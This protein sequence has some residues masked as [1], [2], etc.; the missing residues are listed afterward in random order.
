[1]IDAFEQELAARTAGGALF[2]VAWCLTAYLNTIG[3]GLGE[4][5]RQR[6]W[7]FGPAFSSLDFI[8]AWRMLLRYPALSLVSVFGM[9]VGIAVAATAFVVIDMLMDTR[10]PLPGDD[11]V[12]SLVSYDSATS[13]REFRLANDYAAWRQMASMQEVGIDRT[14]A[15][16][17]IV[18]GRTPEPIR[19]VEISSSAFRVAG[20]GAI[21]GRSLMPEDEA[22]DAPDVVVIGYDEWVRRFEGDPDIIG[23]SVQLGVARH[24]IVGVM[25][26]G[27]AFPA[28]HTFWIPWRVGAASYPPRTGP[29]VSVSGRLAAGVTLESAQAELAEIGRR[30][31]ADSPSTHEHLRPRVLPYVYAFTDMGEPENFFAM[32]AMETGLVLLL[33]IVCVNVAIL[34]Y[35]RTATRQGEIAVRSA[36]GASRR[37]IIAQLFVEAFAMAGVAA[38]IGLFLVWVTLPLLQAEFLSIVGG[39]MPFWLDFHLTADSAL[40]V[41]GLTMLAAAIV[42]VLPALKATSRNVQPGLQTLAAGSGARMQM[43]RLWTLLIVSQVALTVA[44]LPAAMF[45]SWIGL[46]V[47]TGDSG[48]A[49]QSFVRATLAMERPLAEPAGSNEGAFKSRFAASQRELDQRLHADPNVADAT[50]ALMNPEEE[51]AMTLEAEGQPPPADPANY[52]IQEGTRAGHLVR[53]NRVAANYFD[54]FDIPVAVGRDFAPADVG[55]NHVVI[56][57]TLA[58][59]GLRRDKSARPPHQV[60]RQKP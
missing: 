55:T 26:E 8:L 15:R 44:L 39:R 18:E 35:A 24:E 7:R 48:F 33:I 20:V 23:R 59:I 42:G 17:L 51:M 46:R 57:R 12:V 22:R 50:F 6:H 32:T 49:S 16:N 2:R 11:R 41:A 28:N 34:V 31:A 40:F 14:V 37:R 54:A 9:A 25:P 38:A 5:K 10:M 1:M 13:N 21:R 60:R 19:V 4:R 27:F 3:A 43:G 36:L 58:Q 29:H 45:F 30:A 47:R 56:N 53:H 52:N